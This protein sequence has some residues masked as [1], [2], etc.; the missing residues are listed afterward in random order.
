MTRRGSNP[1]PNHQSYAHPT[2]L[3]RPAAGGGGVGVRGHELRPCDPKK[4]VFRGKCTEAFVI[5]WYLLQ[6]VNNNT[7]LTKKLIQYFI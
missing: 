1:R 4:R 2:E 7:A 5:A 6:K 3:P